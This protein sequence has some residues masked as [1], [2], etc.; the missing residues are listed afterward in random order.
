MEQVV[1]A[2]LECTQSD[3]I[4]PIFAHWAIVFFGQFY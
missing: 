2:F 4:G 3:P 1:L